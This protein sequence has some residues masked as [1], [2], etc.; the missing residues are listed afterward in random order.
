MTK[1]TRKKSPA[2]KRKSAVKRKSTV[3]RKR[4]VRKTRRAASTTVKWVKGKHGYDA[5][6]YDSRG[7][8]VNVI[9]YGLKKPPTAKQRATARAALGVSKGYLTKSQTRHKK[10]S[11]YYC[12]VDA[13]GQRSVVLAGAPPTE[14]SHGE[15]FGYA[16]GPFQTKEGAE[17]MAEYGYN[18]PYLLDVADAEAWAKREREE[19]R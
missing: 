1:R 16:I 5:V 17:V 6:K 3:K 13:D 9:N 11:R 7:R 18:N 4:P 8:S 10:G 12:M 15:N 14:E 19:A 2:K